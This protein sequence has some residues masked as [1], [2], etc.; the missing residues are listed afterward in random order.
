M[1]RVKGYLK[2]LIS[3]IL[4]L[5]N[6]SMCNYEKKNQHTITTVTDHLSNLFCIENVKNINLIRNGGARSILPRYRIALYRTA[7]TTLWNRPRDGGTP[8]ERHSLPLGGGD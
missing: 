2:M 8:I 7:G 1:K 3:T 4:A 5:S 6:K